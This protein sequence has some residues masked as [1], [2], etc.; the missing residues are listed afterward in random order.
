MG[1][2]FEARVG[3][4]LYRGGRGFVR[5]FSGEVGDIVGGMFGATP[6]RRSRRRKRIRW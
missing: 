4:A 5:W 1:R 6:R 3:R 2:S